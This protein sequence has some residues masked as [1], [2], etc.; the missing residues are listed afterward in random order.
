[1]PEQGEKWPWV[2]YCNFE[3]SGFR[4]I[5]SHPIRDCVRLGNYN[6]DCNRALL[7]RLTWY[8]EAVLALSQ[9]HKLSKWPGIFIKPDFFQDERSI[10][11]LL[12]KERKKLIDSGT[13]RKNIKLLG[14][15]LFLNKQ[16]YGTV[17]GSVFY[18]WKSQHIF[19]Q[20]RISLPFC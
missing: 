18:S 20:P 16:K 11:S 5:G 3:L 15:T 9:S 14:N 13:E 12:L 2:S 19:N 8:Y 7:V 1:M 6:V 17:K 10:Q 4:H